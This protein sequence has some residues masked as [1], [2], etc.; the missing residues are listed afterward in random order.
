[1]YAIRSYYE[2]LR[3]PLIELEAAYLEAV[4]DEEFIAEFK[5]FQ[6]TFVGRPTPLLHAANASAE[7]GGADIY[8]KLEGLANTGAHKINNALSYNFV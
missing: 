1:M 6:K 2:V 4:N 7:I 5:D 8:I 3:A